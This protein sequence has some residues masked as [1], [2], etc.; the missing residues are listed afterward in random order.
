MRLQ[1]ACARIYGDLFRVY[2]NFLE[3]LHE[4]ESLPTF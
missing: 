1:F 4:H 2:A 3:L